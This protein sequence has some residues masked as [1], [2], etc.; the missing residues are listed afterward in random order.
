MQIITVN[1]EKLQE[2]IRSLLKSQQGFG[3][4]LQATNVITPTVNLNN[5]NLITDDGLDAELINARTVGQQGTIVIPNDSPTNVQSVNLS[6]GFWRV[7]WLIVWAMNEVQLG[8]LWFTAN[9]QIDYLFTWSGTSTNND[10]FVTTQGNDVIFHD[11]TGSYQLNWNF[12]VNYG[13]LIKY[14]KAANLDGSRIAPAGY[15]PAYIPSRQYGHNFPAPPW[16]EKKPKKQ[17]RTGASTKK[18]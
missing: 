9:G 10:E 7:E 15:E 5:S 6:A 11:G 16:K 12:P 13:G 4:E 17:R 1:D 18:D 14:Q 8:S 2:Q 3:E